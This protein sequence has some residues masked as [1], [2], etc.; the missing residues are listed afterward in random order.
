M[1]DIASRLAGRGVSGDQIRDDTKDR[2]VHR[3]QP[4]LH[5]RRHVAERQVRRDEDPPLSVGLLRRCPSSNQHKTTA[6][7]EANL[8]TLENTKQEAVLYQL[9]QQHCSEV[10][11]IELGNMDYPNRAVP[12]KLAAI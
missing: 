8:L 5:R 1:H 2:N 4:L 3:L 9:G 10:F 11:H 7:R 12:L 6:V